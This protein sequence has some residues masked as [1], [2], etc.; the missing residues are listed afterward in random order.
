MSF[1][2]LLTELKGSGILEIKNLFVF[3][4]IVKGES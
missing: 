3:N 1:S 2:I 4:V